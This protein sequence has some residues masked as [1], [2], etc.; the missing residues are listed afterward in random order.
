MYICRT[1]PILVKQCPYRLH[2]DPNPLV[3]QSPCMSF[4]YIYKIYKSVKHYIFIAAA[5][6]RIH[7][8]FVMSD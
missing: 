3:K 7:T 6:I 1:Q 8:N 4:V 2:V 5:H